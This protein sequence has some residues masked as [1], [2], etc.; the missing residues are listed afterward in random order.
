M[1]GQYVVE[2][3]MIGAVRP[4][5]VVAVRMPRARF[6]GLVDAELDCV[7]EEWG[8]DV[9][10]RLRDRLV[11]VARSMPVYPLGEWVTPGRGCGC[12]VG[13][14]LIAARELDRAMLA[15]TH[16]DVEDL[17]GDEQDGD[18]LLMFGEG[19]DHRV[20]QEAYASVD[21]RVIYAAV[22]DRVDVIVIEDEREGGA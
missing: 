19:I 20:R 2:R 4:E 12:V 18:A 1:S 22:G 5:E 16:I 9:A 13:E 21:E 17:L 14:Y 3:L 6:L 7:A 15:R 10:G 11:P 8:A